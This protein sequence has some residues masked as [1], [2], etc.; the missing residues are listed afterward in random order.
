M[1]K[2]KESLSDEKISHLFDQGWYF[3][4]KKVGKY[5]YIITRRGQESLSHGPYNNST[6]AKIKEKERERAHR[7][8]KHYDSQKEIKKDDKKLK[9]KIQKV[10][11]LSKGY[12]E[13]LALYRATIMVGTCK[14]ILNLYCTSWKF[15]DPS[16]LP[17]GIMDWHE[18]FGE[19]IEDYIKKI[20][21]NGQKYWLMRATGIFCIGCTTY[22][23]RD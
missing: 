22:E 9:K 11:A 14:N 19:P 13:N 12:I 20:E 7:T 18:N 6:W 17:I 3:Y 10:M 1:S 23:P 2:D 8:L 21:S 4:R 5:E 15:H 16:L